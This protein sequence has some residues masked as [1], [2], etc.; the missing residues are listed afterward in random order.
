MSP[1]LFE[2]FCDLLE[3]LEEVSKRD[4]PS[5]SNDREKRNRTIIRS[6]FAFHTISIYSTSI[7]PVT[8]LNSLFPA[9]RTDRVYGLQQKSLSRRL[10]GC[11][12]LGHG[13][14][15]Q[16]DQY[17]RPGLDDLGACVERVLKQAEFPKQPPSKQVT[18]QEI[19][20]TLVSLAARCRFSGHK[21]E[22][23]AFS[24][25]T[26]DI[27]SRKY[28]K[29]Q[30]REAKWLTRLILKGFC[31]IDLDA[32]RSAVLS[33][34]DSRLPLALRLY[35]DFDAAI[36]KVLSLPVL[37]HGGSSTNLQTL[38]ARQLMP[39]VGIK[40]SS[41][42]WI[43]AKGGV[44]HAIS[45]ID[46]RVMSVERKYDGEYCQIHVGLSKGKKCIQIFSK[47]GKDST[48]D[49]AG[50]L[51]SIAQSLRIG[52]TECN[53]TS[54]CILE[55]ELVVWSD[56]DSQILE[57][58]KL[59]KHI[60][61]SGVFLGTR[62]DSQ[63][64]DYEHLMVIF[65]DILLLDAQPVLHQPY[66][67]RR[68]ILKKIVKPIK[69]R[70]HFAERQELS[71]SDRTGHTQ[72]RL[73]L[74]EAF[75]RRWEG[76]VLKPA[77]APYF[78][79]KYQLSSRWIKLKKDCICGYGDTA[80]IAVIGAGYDVKR[81]HEL[82]FSEITWT[83]FFL[84]CL[85]NK[86]AVQH[87]N[88]RPC[89]LIVDCV[90]DCIKKT[91]F[92]TLNQYGK[93]A[94]LAIGDE[95]AAKAYE[96]EYTYMDS[97]LPQMTSIFT[98]PFVFEIAGSGFE[99]SANRNIFTLR[100]PR[101]LKVRW[102]RDW[103]DCIDLAQLQ[104]MAKEARSLPAGDLGQEVSAWVMRL[105]D[106]DR[107]IVS[108]SSPRD[109]ASTADSDRR[110]SDTS[111]D[112]KAG[113]GSR[114]RG[115]HK[116]TPPLIRIDS[117][118]MQ[119]DERRQDDGSVAR[120][121]FVRI[122]N[123]ARLSDSPQ[124]TE[125]LVSRRPELSFDLVRKRALD[126]QEHILHVKRT[127]RKAV[128]FSSPDRETTADESSV[129]T[130]SQLHTIH[131]RASPP[132]LI[133]PKPVSKASALPTP[134]S[135]AETTLIKMPDFRNQTVIISASLSEKGQK[136]RTFIKRKTAANSVYYARSREEIA[137]I[138]KSEA[139]ENFIELMTLT[140]ATNIQ[141]ATEDLIDMLACINTLDHFEAALW[142]WRL[143]ELIPKGTQ[144][145][146]KIKEAKDA[147]VAKLCWHKGGGPGEL[148]LTWR[149]GSI[150]SIPEDFIQRIEE[151]ISSNIEECSM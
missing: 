58:H 85:K 57:F 5:L 60:P 83:H 118:E 98:Q 100:F 82:N 40:V 106:V 109:T 30:S 135:S 69:G 3:R 1:L 140:D 15:Q 26:S 8:L 119:Q 66:Q 43:K 99:K 147:F 149:D 4:P 28:I 80:D 6:W 17:Q 117:D 62:E 13:R 141:T 101:V 70:V 44:S 48:E 37:A 12:K 142:D 56:K 89:F 90:T 49:R 52:D 27:L 120:E 150:D 108:R 32:Y 102:D 14:W 91:D 151:A 63:P 95:Q 121:P 74:A 131:A 41:P 97:R 61:R 47:S 42:G 116:T 71:F 105:N 94:A 36:A 73:A 103:R 50:V 148:K 122:N 123:N 21:V 72:L 113:S 134:P 92:E 87:T 18:L 96:L 75:T 79:S 22:F 16:L 84:G 110:Y 76:L 24:E 39:Q 23:E 81:A 45:L 88:A 53:I 111:V 145:V 104:V 93:L 68:T 38:E 51:T 86:H 9:K 77:H 143:L 126:A 25:H 65:Y 7:K 144:A 2:D 11:L 10:R 130:V 35:D 114:R 146:G 20:D 124:T 115:L 132:T 54:E 125:P 129:A 46:S 55:G 64:H 139:P 112:S 136:L 137:S 19:D 133:R 128:G 67:E 31:T 33:C 138:A 127:R 29:L 78:D 34:L 59:R 107:R